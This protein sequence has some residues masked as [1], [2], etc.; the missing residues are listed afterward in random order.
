MKP[1][2]ATSSKNHAELESIELN[3]QTLKKADCVVLTTN[4]SAFDVEFI[5]KH[6]KMIVDMRNMIKDSGEKVYKL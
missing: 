3:E 1:R 6:A 5:Q 4:H 2:F